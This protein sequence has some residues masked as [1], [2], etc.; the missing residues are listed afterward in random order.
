MN[1]DTLKDI[2]DALLRAGKVNIFPHILMDGDAIGS[3]SALCGVLRSKGIDAKVVLED[4]IPDYL[5]FLDDG[6]CTY[7]MASREGADTALCIDCGDRKRFPERAELFDSSPLKICVDHHET[8]DGIGDL[9]YVDPGAAATGEI[10]FELIGELGAGPDRKTAEALFA[11]ITTDTGNFQYSNTTKKTHEIITKLY[12]TGF[13]AYDVSMRLYE[14]EP[15][16]KITLQ[17][18]IMNRAESFAD[19]R[20]IM[21]TVSLGDLERHGA[22]M[23]DT[24]GLVAMMRGI[25]G[26]ELAVLLKENGPDNIKV[27]FRSKKYVDVAAIS[28]RYGGGGHKRAAGCTLHTDL[29]TAKKMMLEAAA[30]AICREY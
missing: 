22:L 3:A 12:D 5:M 27:S 26:V 11:A 19:G 4:K 29:E 16:R 14:N 25:S 15:F 9:N 20:G 10:V 28:A 1:N 18:D 13:R 21:T 30:E 23:E 6:C 17:G 8:S 7:D 24:E 2:A